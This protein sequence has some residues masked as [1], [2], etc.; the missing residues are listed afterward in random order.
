MDYSDNEL[1]VLKTFT[2]TSNEKGYFALDS[3]QNYPYFAVSYNDNYDSEDE[4]KQN[5][6]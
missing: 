3:F 5:Y 1:K 2:T 6:L 4:A